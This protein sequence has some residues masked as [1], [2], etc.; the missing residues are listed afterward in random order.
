MVG[1]SKSDA[2][3]LAMVENPIA[4]NPDEELLKIATAKLVSRY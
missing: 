2:E 4:F 3:M 1:D